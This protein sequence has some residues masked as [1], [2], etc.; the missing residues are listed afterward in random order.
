MGHL[1]HE[2]LASLAS[3]PTDELTPIELT[4][5]EL[6]PDELDHL[7]SCAACSTTLGELNDLVHEVRLARP[8]A[9]SAPRPEVW[10][11]IERELDADE[12]VG[13]PLATPLVRPRPAR[14][15]RRHLVAAVAAAT[16]LVVGV[17][18]T[19]GVL[20]LRRA[21][22]P[23][24]VASTVL[25]ALPGQT[26][27]GTAELVRD[28]DMLQLRVHAALDSSPT[29]YHEVWLINSDGARMYALGILP[30]SGD[31]SYWL[32][33]PGDDRLDG[34]QTVDI[35]LEPEDGDAAHSQH[36]LVRG[37]LPG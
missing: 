31:A 29:A 26:G 14:A 12:P 20:A 3:D 1:S 28:H 30:S 10:A 11:S 32:P 36:S 4:P 17:A 8:S 7:G 9:A 33:T 34:Y 19:L 23:T 22:G 37:Q 2:Q 15:P 24:L 13:R 25:A 5:I 27:G 16:G 18:G 21:D 35:S 6:T